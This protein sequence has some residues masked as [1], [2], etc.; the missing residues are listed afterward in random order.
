MTPN[1]PVARS[2]RY[3][4]LDILRGFSLLGV[5]LANMVT[6]SGYFFLSAESQQSMD[7]ATLDR[8]I[9]WL[10]HF[11]IDGKFYSLFSL[12]F[13]IGFSLQMKRAGE[14]QAS[15]LPL[16]RRRLLFMFVF[17]VLH[18]VLLY[19][20]DILTVYAFTG[21]ILLLYQ[22]SN[23]KVV[24]R[25]VFIFLFLPV[26]QYLIMQLFHV[27]DPAPPPN[28][29][30]NSNPLFDQLIQTYRT[31]SYW[32][33]V[34]N[35]IGGLLF[36]RYP[37]LFFTGRFFRVLAMFLLGMYI[38]RKDLLRELESHRPLFKK[39]QLYGALIGIPCNLIL[40]DRMTTPS[41]YNLEPTG[42]IQPLVYAFGVPALSLFYAASLALLFL[43]PVWKIR[44][45]IFAP[46]GQMALTNYLMQSVFCVFIFMSYGLGKEATYGPAILS[47]IAIGIYF[48]QLLYS[49]IWLKY[50]HFGPMEWLWRSLT[51][52]KIQLF[53]K[54]YTI[55]AI[56]E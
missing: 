17:G 15:F 14:T 6:H 48:L 46:V 28:E 8:I 39:T 16:F 55:D 32:E 49:P 9:E 24:L 45:R 12:L 3:P 50:F 31:G 4:F 43:H 2:E 44:L 41:Y 35:N 27:S 5:L 11:L 53:R 40:A 18:A 13:G 47:L 51:Y 26:I 22:N 33:I 42:I 10:E 37:D 20:G 54:K 34:Q 23:D 52:R 7:T 30:G 56:N 36:G 21:F 29:G 1:Q 19:V 38:A 25:S